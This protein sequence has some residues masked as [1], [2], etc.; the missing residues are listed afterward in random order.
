M[1]IEYVRFIERRVH[2]IQYNGE[3]ADEI[4]AYLRTDDWASDEEGRSAQ[5]GDWLYLDKD[6]MPAILSNRR[7]LKD[8]ETLRRRDG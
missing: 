8:T 1:K 5:P 3:N 2:M 6:N 7:K 4:S